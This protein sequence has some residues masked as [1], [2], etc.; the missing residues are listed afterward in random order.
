MMVGKKIQIA[1][2]LLV[3]AVTAG[4]ILTELTS[5]VVLM[6]AGREIQILYVVGG[7]YESWQRNPDGTYVCRGA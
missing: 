1:P 3:V 6:T 4:K 7:A 2:M 5:A